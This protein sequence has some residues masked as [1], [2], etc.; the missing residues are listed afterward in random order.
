MIF[1][2]TTAFIFSKKAHGASEAFAHTIHADFHA[3]SR[4]SCHKIITIP[5]YENYL[6]ESV[7]ALTYPVLKKKLG[8]KSKI[9]FRCN[10]N[11]FSDEP[12]RYFQGNFFVRKYITFLLKHTDGIIPVSPM[13]QKDINEK[14]ETY[15]KKKIPSVVV[16]SFVGD[17]KRWLA[18]KPN[19]KSKNF[20]FVGYIRNHKGIDILL[21]TFEL[22]NKKHPDAQ[23]F[24]AGISHDDL[25]RYHLVA[26]KNVHPIGFV[27]NLEDYFK[28]C[29][30]YFTTPR[31][32]PGP[33][34]SLEAM[35][36]GLIPIVNDRTGH[37]DH[38]AQI[39]K[40]LVIHSLVPEEI[41]AQV[42]KIMQKRNFK[43]LSDKSR[44]VAL[45]YTKEKQL[46]KFQKAFA[47][48][49]ADNKE[50]DI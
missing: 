42:I 3:V 24:L 37:Q 6:I 43:T 16:H 21:K 14:C 22:I 9:V 25:K 13:V 10:S 7:F 38:V 33:T 39:D 27:K 15:L 2:N 45:N 4:F 8:A 28:Q 40:D 30:F 23:L 41:A 46:K 12:K 48:L 5:D 26:P 31:Y 18:V 47:Q 32:E 11:L 50:Q 17:P 44:K 35:C 1:M 34:A 29:A 49:T 36:A 20:V 19:L